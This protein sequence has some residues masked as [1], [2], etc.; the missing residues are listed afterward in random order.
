MG[1]PIGGHHGRLRPGVRQVVVPYAWAILRAAGGAVPVA[2]V[3]TIMGLAMVEYVR[4][5]DLVVPMD[6]WRSGAAF[7]FGL[8][9]VAVAIGIVRAAVIVRRSR[10]SPAPVPADGGV[11]WPRAETVGLIVLSLTYGV[12]VVLVFGGPGP[13]EDLAYG[14]DRTACAMGYGALYVI[15]VLGGLVVWALGSLL[16]SLVWVMRT[17]IDAWATSHRS[18]TPS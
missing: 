11:P 5:D 1:V 14:S 2:V 12:I 18:N 4:T 10:R 17:A 8:A 6:V 3:L 15:L 9:A 13:C 7:A 16:L